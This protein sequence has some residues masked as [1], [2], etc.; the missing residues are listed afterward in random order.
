[1]KRKVPDRVRFVLELRRSSAAG[2]RTS[3]KPRSAKK[4]DAIKDQE[5]T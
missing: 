4:R 2:S 3:E 5:S 1:M